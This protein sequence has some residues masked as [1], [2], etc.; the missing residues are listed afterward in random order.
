[1]W[2][3]KFASLGRTLI[4]PSHE[5]STVPLG[6][7]LFFPATSLIL[8]TFFKNPLCQKKSPQNENKTELSLCQ[9][10]FTTV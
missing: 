3:Y 6:F 1:M 10:K 9:K 8:G 5:Q 4:L 2:M 7:F